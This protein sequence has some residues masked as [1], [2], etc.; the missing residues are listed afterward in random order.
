MSAS[1]Q[2]DVK[3]PFVKR[4][5]LGPFV[6]V[7]TVALLT[8]CLEYVMSEA[9]VEIIQEKDLLGNPWRW[10]FVGTWNGEVDL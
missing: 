9:V 1:P 5:T 10:S 4:V 2:E 3:I 8:G 7:P 6:G